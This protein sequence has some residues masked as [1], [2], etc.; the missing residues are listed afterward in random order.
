[1]ENVF[2]LWLDMIHKQ[3]QT[4]CVLQITLTICTG[5]TTLT[6][7]HIWMWKSFVHRRT[8]PRTNV[9]ACSNIS[10]S[11]WR[12][13]A[14]NLHGSI[15]RKAQRAPP[16][17]EE[18]KV[19]IFIF[20]SFLFRK[21]MA[22]QEPSCRIQT[23]TLA[24]EMRKYLA[25]NNNANCR[26]NRTKMALNSSWQH[27]KSKSALLSMSRADFSSRYTFIVPLSYKIRI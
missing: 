6:H 20:F 13:Y 14:W 8:S 17:C 3:R 26:T 11:F 12:K 27:K 18:V 16:Q 21:N 4:H 10:H 25:Y 23:L 9:R 15:G 24:K 7:T 5:H 2:I 1:M 19:V 22:K